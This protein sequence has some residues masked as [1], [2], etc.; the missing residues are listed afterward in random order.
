MKTMFAFKTNM[1][2]LF[3]Y[4]HN[5]VKPHHILKKTKYEYN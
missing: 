4:Y 5:P 2:F 3:F 1:V